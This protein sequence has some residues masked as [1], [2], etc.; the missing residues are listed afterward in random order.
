MAV[1]RARREL[2]LSYPILRTSPGYSGDAYQLPSRF[3]KEI[4]H[5]LVDEWALKTQ[6]S[7]Y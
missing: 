7:F 3:L 5:D 6:D 4:P 1:T 2:Y